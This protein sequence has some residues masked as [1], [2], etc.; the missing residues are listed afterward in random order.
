L[1]DQL[2]PGKVAAVCG[3]G[4]MGKSALAEAMRQFEQNPD[5][6]ARKAVLAEEMEKSGAHE[7][8]ELRQA[9]GKLQELLKAVQPQTSVIQHVS[10]NGNIFS[11]TGNVE[12][13]R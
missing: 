4:G 7:D 1:L 3:P 13:K 10:G 11:G 12:V 6:A 5:S 8:A 2:Q 9:A